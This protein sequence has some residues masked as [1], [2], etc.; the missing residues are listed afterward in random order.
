M[1]YVG[2]ARALCVHVRT[3]DTLFS[4]CD[5]RLAPMTTPPKLLLA[6]DQLIV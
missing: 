3:I 2:V 4:G 6:E 1:G 5:A